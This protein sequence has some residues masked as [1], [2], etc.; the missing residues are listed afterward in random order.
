[1]TTILR[2]AAERRKIMKC[3]K[4]SKTFETP[5]M[6]YSGK[7]ACPFCGEFL[8]VAETFEVTAESEEY[9]RLSELAWFRYLENGKLSYIKKCLEYCIR[10]A[11][12]GHPK[13]ILR[14]G[15]LYE[16]GY[17][18][19]GL[20][21]IECGRIAS[22]YYNSLCFFGKQV[23]ANGISGYD[24][25]SMSGIKMLAA[26]RLWNLVSTLAGANASVRPDGSAVKELKSKLTRLYPSVKFDDVEVA[27][28]ISGSDLASKLQS[29]F[30]KTRAPVFGVIK[31]TAAELKANVDEIL[32]RA[33]QGLDMFHIVCGA[34]GEVDGRSK[35][36]FNALTNRKRIVEYIDATE[37]DGYL[38]FFNTNGKHPY[39]GRQIMEKVRDELAE[40][41]SFA[42]VK[43]LINK[44]GRAEYTFYDDDIFAFGN[45]AKKLIDD[46]IAERKSLLF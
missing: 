35:N 16:T 6:L 15:Y 22:G 9:F 41:G 18:S 28:E 24:E 29:C 19:A 27:G 2:R 5:L 1:M 14:L 34:G 45:S 39:V 26:K 4:C 36:A 20:G 13:A 12:T 8:A 7:T 44:G 3:V 38:Y 17:A 21:R 23:N 31:L 30:D 10:A 42:L 37:S 46:V 40:D 25:E 33:H 43:T 32:D 11:H